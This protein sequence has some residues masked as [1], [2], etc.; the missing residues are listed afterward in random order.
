MTITGLPLYPTLYFLLVALVGVVLI[1]ACRG[2]DIARAR[3]QRRYDR[4][5]HRSDQRALCIRTDLRLWEAAHAQAFREQQKRHRGKL[6]ALYRWDREFS[7][8]QS[9]AGK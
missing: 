7:E 6:M 2:A 4:L 5:E 3:Q 1:L 8:L 9:G